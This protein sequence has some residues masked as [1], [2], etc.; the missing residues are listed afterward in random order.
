MATLPKI[1]DRIN[2]FN[3]VIINIIINKTAI[4]R[5]IHTFS[6]DFENSTIIKEDVI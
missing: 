2:E 5:H 3:G 4:P 1:E 6:V